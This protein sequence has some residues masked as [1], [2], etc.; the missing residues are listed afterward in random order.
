MRKLKAI[1]SFSACLELKNFHMN[2][3]LVLSLILL[4]SFI[5]QT[6]SRT[7]NFP[8]K[9]EYVS[10]LPKKEDFWIFI[11]AGQSNMAGRGLVEPED[12]IPSPN[13]YTLN[14]ENKWV[15]AKEPL[16]YYEPN[17]TGLDCG[18]SFAKDV[19][20]AAGRRVVIGIV[21]T[22]VGGSAIE[23]WLGDSTYRN[24][25]LYTNFKNK[26]EQASQVG[27]IKGILWHQGESN[28]HQKPFKNYKTNLTTLFSKFRM[29]AKNEKLPI[30]A[31]ELGSFV[32][33][34]EFHHYNDSVNLVLNRL[35][36]SDR[37]FYVIKTSDLT[38]KGDSL[39]FDSKSQRL[40]GK[41]LAAQYLKIH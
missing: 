26:I 21:P 11:M 18:L 19:S 12:T 10:G 1:T 36:K 8:K 32:R 27:T 9:V 35:A 33:E 24:V 3:L 29:L 22:A 15:L 13:V 2:K 40:I 30:L 14:K 7:A 39:H 28:A 6:D 16:H 4:S 37:N 31:G 23:Q 25:K 34:R 41:R 20:N 17:L 5:Q 38:H